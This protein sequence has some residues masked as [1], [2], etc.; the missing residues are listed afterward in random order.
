M[1]GFIILIFIIIIFIISSKY[2]IETF[3]NYNTNNDIYNS[4]I[5]YKN[6]DPEFFNY[7]RNLQ[8]ISTPLDNIDYIN[9][10]HYYYEHNNTDYLKKMYEIFNVNNDVNTLIKI[11]HS[12]W[13]NWDI[14]N[15]KVNKI[16][17]KFLN[18]FNNI[19]RPHKIF[20]IYTIFKKFKFNNNNTNNLLIDSDILLYRNNKIHG[21]HLNVLIYYNNNKFHIINFNII[22]IV[23]QFN[24][25]NNSYLKDIN[26]SNHV[27]LNNNNHFN[28][29]CESNCDSQLTIDDH[30]V[31][32]KIKNNILNNLVDNSFYNH[33]SIKKNQSYF[34][35]QNLIKNK[36]F[37]NKLNYKT[38]I[39]PF[40][41]F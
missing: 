21:K 8:I 33:D 30:F 27:D 35:L 18:Y 41:S 23:S 32:N 5:D 34:K 26:L 28:F 39:K 31:D 20:N 10:K 6:Y 22:G 2:F 9:N 13:S 40:N 11:N 3:F 37:T 29:N 17:Y 19:I 24:I 16:Y 25:I 36:L 38:N 7:K 1:K 15:K 14:P 4:T 12:D